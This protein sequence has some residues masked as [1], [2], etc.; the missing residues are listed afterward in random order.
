MID[1]EEQSVSGMAKRYHIHKCSELCSFLIIA[2]AFINLRGQLGH[3]SVVNA[4]AG[5]VIPTVI[6]ATIKLLPHLK[7]QS[8]KDAVSCVR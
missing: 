6:P 3:G 8:P 2:I 7:G 1:S 4:V 5:A